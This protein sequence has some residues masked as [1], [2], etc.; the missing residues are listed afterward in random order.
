[1]PPS[2]SVNR[3]SVDRKENRKHGRINL[4]KN[5]STCPDYPSSTVVVVVE[6][7]Y[8]R[9]FLD[10]FFFLDGGHGWDAETWCGRYGK[11]SC[12]GWMGLIRCESRLL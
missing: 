10:L 11:Q 7:S 5:S 4:G 3:D 2:G 9:L 8:A 12:E 6:L 1:M